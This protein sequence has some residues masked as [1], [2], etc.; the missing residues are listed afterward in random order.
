MKCLRSLVGYSVASSLIS[1]GVL[2]GSVRVSQADGVRA[3]VRAIVHLP[4][5]SGPP[6]TVGYVCVENGV[7]PIAPPHRD[8]RRE[9]IVVLQ[10]VQPD[11]GGD[12]QA[13]RPTSPGAPPKSV[14][15]R[16]FGMRFLPEVVAVPP[17]AQVVLRND[18]RLPVTLQSREAPRL[19]AAAA[20]PPGGTLVLAPP[21][22]DSGTISISSAEYPQMRATLLVPRGP[23]RVVKWSPGGEAG[24]AELE[25]APGVY[26]ARLF[27]AHHYVASQAVS[28]PESGTEV[29]LRAAGPLPEERGT[30]E[31]REESRP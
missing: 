12:E 23:H 14:N 28:V 22:G 18:D 24:V 1:L 6:K 7:L 17:G 10:P 20:L 3:A 2:A 27:F 19:F 21:S 30:A 31:R 16:I 26:Q 15:I 4:R 29:V 13:A 5:P 25:V 11:G 8:P 9:A